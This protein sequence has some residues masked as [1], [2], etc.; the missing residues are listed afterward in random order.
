VGTI[1]TSPEVLSDYCDF[2]IST[3]SHGEA[4]KGLRVA[5]D[6][7]N[8]ATY[9]VA[10]VVLKRLGAEVMV[11]N[12][13]PDGCNINA[14]CGS[15]FLG[16]LSEY[17]RERGADIGLAFDGDGDRVLAVDE[18]G[19]QMSGD[20]IMSICAHHLKTQGRLNNDT[21]VVTVMSNLGLKLMAERHG[22]KIEETAVGDR[23]VLEKMMEGGY[24]LGGEDSGHIIFLA[25]NTT[26]DGILTG[27][28][29][30]KILKTSGKRCSRLNTLME[31]MPQVLVNA[32]V[33]NE[34][35]HS[36]MDNIE[37]KTAVS[38]LEKRFAGE[39][40]VLIRPSGTEP[41]IRVMMEGR[42]QQLLEAEA[43]KIAALLERLLK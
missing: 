6:C 10:P 15:T 24:S 25:H 37:I 34:K 22:I 40:R 32:K 39:G 18:T 8:G 11:I 13:A 9:R 1:K 38:D 14:R 21:L 27:L 31:R 17:V 19:T 26:G 43:A 5:V 42:D 12:D 2:L 16:P 20:E 35:K 23:Y 3:I 4:L 41:V 36:Y 30:L 29:L 28:Q 7:A 33:T